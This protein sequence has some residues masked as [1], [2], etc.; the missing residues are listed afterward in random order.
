MDSGALS[1]AEIAQ[2]VANRKLSALAVTEAALARIARHDPA[3]SI[4]LPT[5]PPIAPAPRRAP[6]MSP[7]QTDRKWARS[8][9]CRSR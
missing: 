4:P 2:A 8:P 6:S 7:S 3:S 5:S 1:A 9:A